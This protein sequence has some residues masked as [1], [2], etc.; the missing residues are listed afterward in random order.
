L[1]ERSLQSSQAH[2]EVGQSLGFSA[3]KV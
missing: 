2:T 3:S 1:T